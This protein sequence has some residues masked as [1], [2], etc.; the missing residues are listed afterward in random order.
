MARRAN[1]NPKDD[2][3]KRLLEDI[4]TWA[5]HTSGNLSRL[6]YDFE[7]FSREYF[8]IFRARGH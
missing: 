7:V 3:Q 6:L 1:K 5:K 8:Y 4:Q 2:D